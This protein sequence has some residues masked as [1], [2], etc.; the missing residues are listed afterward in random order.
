VVGSLL[1]KQTYNYLGMWDPRVGLWHCEGNGTWPPL[2]P[3]LSNVLGNPG[4][5]TVCGCVLTHRYQF[6]LLAAPRVPFLRGITLT[7]KGEARFEL[8]FVII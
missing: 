4:T 3:Y 8:C 6:S 2:S 1:H 7:S 5:G